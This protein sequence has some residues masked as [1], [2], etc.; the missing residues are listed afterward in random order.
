M[1]MSLEMN[2]EVITAR[3]CAGTMLALVSLIACMQLY[4][5]VST[6]FV[7]ERS[8]TIIAGIN[9]ILIMMIVMVAVRQLLVHKS[10]RWTC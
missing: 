1:V 4:V 7:L 2:F 3:E 10:G 5:P 6:S 9:C 8:I